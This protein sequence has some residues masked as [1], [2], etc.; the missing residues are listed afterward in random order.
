MYRNLVVAHG[1]Q[2]DELDAQAQQIKRLERKM[3]QLEGCTGSWKNRRF[4][5]KQ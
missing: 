1:L 4:I 2:R 3:S 5:M